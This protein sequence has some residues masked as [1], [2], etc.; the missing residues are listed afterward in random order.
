MSL[1][2]AAV[3][4]SRRLGGLSVVA[5][6]VTGS[7]L[8]SCGIANDIRKV[9]ANIEGNQRVM[10]GFTS[11]IQQGES[12][13]FEATYT[14][15]GSAPATVVYAAVP[16]QNE[17]AFTDTPTG[18]A[19]GPDAADYLDLIENPAGFYSCTPATPTSGATCNRYGTLSAADQRNLLDFY[20]PSHWISF[21]QGLA[22]AAGFA[23]DKVTTSAMTVNGFTMSCVDFGAPGVSG[24]STICTAGQDIL[25]YV[26]VAGD[27]TS[28]E[29]TAYSASPPASLFQP[30]PGATIT[31]EPLLPTS[32]TTTST[33]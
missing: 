27:S 7:C 14:T 1:F 13:T 18:G 12:A 9:K 33:S 32:S 31:T 25:G 24:T 29:L 4:R 26:K 19:N 15:T 22:L 23:G 6:V 5:L 10:A 3:P 17:V 30:P 20:T 21:L 16:A 11:R 28:F 8:P 2:H